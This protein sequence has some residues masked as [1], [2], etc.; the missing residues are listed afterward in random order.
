MLKTILCLK[1]CGLRTC[2]FWGFR[3]FQLMIDRSLILEPCN[4]FGHFVPPEDKQ[5]QV[6]NS[7]KTEK[8]TA[9]Y[10]SGLYQDCLVSDVCVNCKYEFHQYARII[11]KCYIA[12]FRKL[13]PVSVILLLLRSS[14][15]SEISR[16]FHAPHTLSTIFQKKPVA[17]KFSN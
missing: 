3:L 4:I 16:H 15:I 2:L 7:S 14:T 6:E 11:S 12:I 1:I 9:S 10:S 5:T 13:F 8:T 17:S